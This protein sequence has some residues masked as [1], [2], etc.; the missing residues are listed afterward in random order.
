MPAVELLDLVNTGF[1]QV[2]RD[3]TQRAFKNALT[4]DPE[5]TAEH[6]RRFEVHME[7]TFGEAW[8]DLDTKI[9]LKEYFNNL[10]DEVGTMAIG[11]GESMVD[12]IIRGTLDMGEV[13]KR[14]LI[15]FALTFIFKPLKIALGILSPSKITMG[16]G[17]NLGEG[18]VAG[19]DAVGP[20][21]ANAAQRM[22]DAALVD[23]QPVVLPAPI[24][25]DITPQLAAVTA[26][27][28]DTALAGL[29]PAGVGL[30]GVLG[31]APVIQL[32][33]PPGMD[34]HPFAP[35]LMDWFGDMDARVKFAG[36]R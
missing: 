24:V 13:L 19:M 21:V 26:R 22:A 16:L 2:L 23:L 1:G 34:A 27:P 30:G 14:F 10:D 33:L 17:R 4:L 29:Q 28:T 36:G 18:L 35:A 6:A 20:V 11:I 3:Q 8:R 7:K 9:Q 15:G 32:E 31:D 12:G 25:P 5:E